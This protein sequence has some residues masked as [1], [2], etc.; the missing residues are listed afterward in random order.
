MCRSI[1]TGTTERDYGSFGGGPKSTNE[2]LMAPCTACNG[3]GQCQQCKGTG[4]F[5]YPGRGPVEN[6]KNPCVRCQSSGV[7]SICKGKGAK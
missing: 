3:T 2:A 4:R 5:G 7:C 1:V 6:Y